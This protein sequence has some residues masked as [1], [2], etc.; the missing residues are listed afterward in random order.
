MK[1]IT[2][3][4]TNVKPILVTTKTFNKSTEKY[5]YTKKKKTITTVSFEC[6]TEEEGLSYMNNYVDDKQK[7]EKSIEVTKHYFSNIL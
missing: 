6:K 2:F 3:H 5:D 7:K 1:R 4:L